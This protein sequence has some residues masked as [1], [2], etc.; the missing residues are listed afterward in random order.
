MLQSG[1]VA[2]SREDRGAGWKLMSGEVPEGFPEE[3]IHRLTMCVHDWSGT[4]C[5]RQS[6][7]A[8]KANPRGQ[9]L[10]AQEMDRESWMAF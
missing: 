4:P 10:S 5:K 7:H 9:P 8:P 2:H 6:V 1:P 3:D